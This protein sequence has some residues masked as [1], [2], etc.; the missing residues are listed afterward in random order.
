MSEIPIEFTFRNMDRSDALEAEARRRAQKLATLWSG[1]ISCR[2]VGEVAQRSPVQPGTRLHLFRVEVAVPGE[3]I[4]ASNDLNKEESARDPYLA[5]REA[6]D[7]A[8]RRLVDRVGRLRVRTGTQPP[9]R[10]GQGREQDQD[11]E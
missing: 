10:Q 1:V 2:I 7:A 9:A 8:E 11:Q 5:M 6:F 4:H 3:D